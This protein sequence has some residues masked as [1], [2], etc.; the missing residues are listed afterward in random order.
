MEPASS[1][2]PQILD[3]K[4][5]LLR[6]LGEGGMGAVYEGRHRGTGRRVAVKVIGGDALHSKSGEIISRFQREAMASGSL[7]SQYIAQV[8]DTGID[9]ATNS[10]YLVMELLT[11]DDLEKTIER[12]GGPLPP[13]LA[14]RAMAHACLGLN[15]AHEA[16]VIHRDIKPANLFLARRE[17]GEIV[18]K[19]LDFGIAKATGNALT[20]SGNHAKTRT[21]MMLG[22]PVYMSPE[23]AMGRKSIDHRTDIWSLGVVLYEALCGVTPHGHAETI[24]ELVIR[25]CGE[26]PQNLQERAPWVPPEVAA[27]AHKALALDPAARFQTAAEMLAAVRARLP[28]G[29]ALDESMLAPLSGATRAITAPRVS[30]TSDV[31]HPSPSFPEF[32]GS[33]PDLALL[34]QAK[35]TAASLALQT[36]TTAGFGQSGVSATTQVPR[37][38]AF[39]L[40]L[41][42]VVALGIGAGAVFAFRGSHA[43]SPAP[44]STQA[45][46]AIAPPVTASA[47]PPV[48]TPLPAAAPSAAATA[49]AAEA[50]LPAT[51]QKGGTTSRPSAHSPHA[52]APP[53]AV[54][55]PSAAPPAAAPPPPPPA[56]TP[57][58][59]YN[60]LDHL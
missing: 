60:P 49:G 46:A 12:L 34:A 55:H 39:P 20:D 43:S 11:G 30:L 3:G 42:A 51:P 56:A 47:A 6:K 58:A 21:G 4:Y 14:L 36:R 54:S 33:S 53:P 52:G 17:G 28:G 26:A 7:E 37:S 24:G 25:I 8:L 13:D 41:T 31:K 40:A 50:E 59:K 45:S 48:A 44:V 15:K 32:S 29:H 16:G 10:P 1:A 57:S 35:L 23:Q 19:L 5:E 18:V 27:I 22:S 38:R 9:A 2:S